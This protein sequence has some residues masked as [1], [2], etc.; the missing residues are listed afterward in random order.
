VAVAEDFP[1]V[2]GSSTGDRFETRPRRVGSVGE[3]VSSLWL[4]ERA[5]FFEDGSGSEV[6]LFAEVV[7]AAVV[8]VVVVLVWFGLLRAARKWRADAGGGGG[9]VVELELELEEEGGEGLN[10][11]LDGVDADDNVLSLLRDRSDLVRTAPV[12]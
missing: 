8:C 5:R 4:I 11:F 10:F 9:H 3:D 7:L 2:L 12:E 6:L 1:F